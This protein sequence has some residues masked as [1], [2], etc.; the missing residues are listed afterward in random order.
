VKKISWYSKPFFCFLQWKERQ[1][2]ILTSIKKS[3]LLVTL[4]PVA[5]FSETEPVLLNVYGASELIP[6]NEFRQTM[7]SILA[8]RYENPIPPRCLATIDFLKIQAQEN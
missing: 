1:A 8:G 4:V 7:Y 2:S 3:S 5:G 6:R